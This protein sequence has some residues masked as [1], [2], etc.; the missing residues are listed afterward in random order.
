M[1]VLLKKH[2]ILI[3]KSQKRALRIVY[4]R[5]EE[6]FENILNTELLSTIHN[7]N[8]QSLMCEVFKSLNHM[9]PEFMWDYFLI[10]PLTINLR[11]KNILILPS[12][13]TKSRGTNTIHYRAVSI[14][15]SL[16]KKLMSCNKFHYFK[17][18]IKKILNI[19]CCYRICN[20]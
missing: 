18:N 8:I 3:N 11:A 13:K 1:D 14:W 12:N 10:K 5:P 16:D 15:N 9:N 20:S 6:T 2:N 7:R 17:I 19:R 4:N